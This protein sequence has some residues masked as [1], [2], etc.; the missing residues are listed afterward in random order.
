MFCSSN[1]T[2]VRNVQ[3]DFPQMAENGD[4]IE[5]NCL[6]ESNND[7]KRVQWYKSDASNVIATY[8]ISEI[9]VVTKEVDEE[10][11]KGNVIFF[12]DAVGDAREFL[13]I[14]LESVDVSQRGEYGCSVS[15]V[16][17]SMDIKQV[18]NF[19]GLSIDGK[20]CKK[21]KVF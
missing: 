2:G 8:K 13:T 16:G 18:S 21:K 17:H 14:T 20:D 19:R 3:I 11:D 4:D 5:V 6:W 7:D 9:N 15:M 12:G 1:I 10:E